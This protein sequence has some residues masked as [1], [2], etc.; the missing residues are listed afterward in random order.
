MKGPV[1][2]YQHEWG[3]LYEQIWCNFQVIPL[4]KKSEEHINMLNFVWGKKEKEFGLCKARECSTY[5]KAKMKL[6]GRERKEKPQPESRKKQIVFQINMITTLYGEGK[7]E[8]R[9]GGSYMHRINS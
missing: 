1:Y 7:Q 5:L 8:G 4:S 9:E 2:S 3:Y 6:M